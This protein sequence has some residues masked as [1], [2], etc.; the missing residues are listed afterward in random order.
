MFR[1]AAQ[2]A[3]KGA[4]EELG[5]EPICLRTPVLARHR[6]DRRMDNKSHH[7]HRPQ[8]ARQPEYVA[9]GLDRREHN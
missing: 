1:F 2:P 3:D 8:P 5:V 7:S 6:D 9:A 4:L